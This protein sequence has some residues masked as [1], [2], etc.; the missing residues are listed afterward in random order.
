MPCI[1]GGLRTSCRPCGRPCRGRG[2]WRPLSRAKAASPPAPPGPP[3]RRRTGSRGRV[4]PG[5]LG[6]VEVE[7]AAEV[8]A[9]G[10]APLGDAVAAKCMPEFTFSLAN[11]T[12]VA[13]GPSRIESNVSAQRSPCPPRG[14]RGSR[15][16]RCPS[17]GPTCAARWPSA[18]R[19]ENGQQPPDEGQPSAGMWSWVAQR[20][21][22]ETTS[23]C[24]R[25]H[26]SSC[27]VAL[28]GVAL[29]GLVRLATDHQQLAVGG[30]D[31]AQGVGRALVA[32]VHPLGRRRRGAAPAARRSARGGCGRSRG[33]GRGWACGSRRSRGPP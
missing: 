27:R 5:L 26:S 28:A 8:G 17:P 14:R 31:R 16:P 24:S 2:L 25:A 19:S 20:Y 1:A 15:R 6:G 7:E 23:K 33:R 11:S 21:S 22:T 13:G 18:R 30:R 10:V 3:R 12:A 32:Q 9:P 4:V 29:P